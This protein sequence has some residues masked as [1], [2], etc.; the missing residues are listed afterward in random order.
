MGTDFSKVLL[1]GLLDYSGVKLG[2]GRVLLDSDFNELTDILD[3]RLRALASDVLDRATVSSTTPDAFKIEAPAGLTIGVGRLYVDGLLAECHGA[4]STAAVERGLDEV[5]DEARF[6]KPVPYTA[7]PYLRQPPPLPTTGTHLVYLDVWQRPVTHLEQPKLVETA[8]G[9]DAG[10]REQIAW[11]VRI[12]APSAGSGATCA[13]PDDELPG[14]ADLIAPSTGVLT[15][16][17][18]EVAPVTDPCELPPTGGYRGLENQL[19]RVEIHAPGQPRGG[20]AG[21]P[22]ATFKWSRENKSVGS[23][24]VSMK[25]AGDVEVESLGRDDILSLK[26]GD[27]VEFMNDYRE[28]AQ[29][30]GEM[31]K[32]AVNAATRRITF[33]QPLPGDLAPGPFP[34]STSPAARNLRVRRWD[35]KGKI[36]RTGANGPVEDQDLDTGTSGLIDVPATGTTLILENGVTVEFGST[37]SKGFRTG[38]YWVFAARTTDASVEELDRARPRGI[39]HNYARLAIWDAAAGT[40]TD[41]RNKWP[42]KGGDD[43]SCTACVT[44]DSHNGGQFT[45]QAAVDKVKPT[46]GTVCLG[47][48]QYKLDDPVRIDGATS[49][50]IRGQG[51]ASLI[52][53]TAGAFEIKECLFSAVEN[54]GILSIGQS[55]AIIVD[56][57]IGLSLTRIAALAIGGDERSGGGIAISLQGIVA[58]ATI[59]ENVIFAATGIRANSFGFPPQTTPAPTGDFS[60]LIAAALKI[61]DNI[62]LCEQSAV[63]LDG[64]V[65]YILG[66][67][68]TGNEIAGCRDFAVSTLG[69]GLLLS[70]MTISRNDIMVPQGGIR[71]GAEGIW[72]DSNRLVNTE[73]RGNAAAAI[74]LEAGLLNRTGIDQCHI[75]A[76]QISDFGGTAIDIGV[77]VG[78]LIAKQNIIEHCG[79]G[80]VSFP[81]GQ[82]KAGKLIIENNLLHDIG[83][84]TES[85]SAAVNGIAVLHA[86]SA[87]IAGNTIRSLAVQPLGSA[88]SKAIVTANVDRARILG[89][90]ATDIGPPGAFSGAAAGIVVVGSAT[91]F[92]ICNNRIEPLQANS[93]ATWTALV[94]GP[95]L[96]SV[97]SQPSPGTPASV[98]PSPAGSLLSTDAGSLAMMTFGGRVAIIIVQPSRPSGSILDNVIT[99]RSAASAVL[100]TAGECLFSDN[101]VT[102][103][104]ADAAKPAP[105]TVNL[106]ASIAIVNANRVKGGNPSINLTTPAGK[107]ASAVGNITTAGITATPPLLA[108]FVLLNLMK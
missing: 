19:Y 24:I 29:L 87:T 58:G 93:V 75:L 101:R 96:A 56:T 83:P 54:L 66:T 51:L 104:L 8:V 25:N 41:C 38:D 11:Q 48:G 69:R 82:A 37:G 13:T 67:R 90:E 50:R 98:A 21:Q 88:S 61:D 86:A 81:A 45:I 16:G 103:P 14:W 99:S 108:P 12:L 80:I 4:E 2:Q 94:V 32:I 10:A 43:C 68:I 60:F 63:A 95:S 5:L 47:P 28:F 74:K 17:T 77:R 65:M 49:L 44:A 78:A 53:A 39:W 72:I 91:D 7:Q 6:A 73:S 97:P 20:P 71:C 52:V 22:V 33:A 76:N 35:Q 100:I 79:Q 57:A 64:Y 1:N 102:A 30:P 55:P 89:N 85:P 59:S 62:F 84:R 3:R 106:S 18:Y 27:W 42:P 36:Y 70:S 107:Q 40:L 31:R 23:R 15:T 26:T 9:V 46:G 92:E 105:P 34:D